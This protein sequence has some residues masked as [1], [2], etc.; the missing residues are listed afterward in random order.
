M[1]GGATRIQLP[2]RLDQRDPRRCALA[3]VDSA[4]KHHPDK[5]GDP[6]LFKEL[7]HAY[8]VLSD[9]NKRELYDMHGKAGLE[10]GGMGGGG[11]D[12]QDLFS[13]LFGGGGG[14]FGGGGESSAS[15]SAS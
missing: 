7:T 13:Q 4:L 2:S 10:G 8:E 15:A 9:G 12:P 3:D 14:F 11:M 6:E 1:S 5:G